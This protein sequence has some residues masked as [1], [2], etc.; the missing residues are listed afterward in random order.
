MAIYDYKCTECDE[1]RTLTHSVH[2]TSIY[3]CEKCDSEMRKVYHAPATVFPGEGWGKD[4][5]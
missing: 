3:F 2:S 4:A 1:T 5:R